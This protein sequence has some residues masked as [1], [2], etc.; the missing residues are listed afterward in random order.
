MLRTRH[1]RQAHDLARWLARAH[2]TDRIVI[3]SA[4]AAGLIEVRLPRHLEWPDPRTH[5][6]SIAALPA[7]A[8]DAHLSHMDHLSSPGGI[9]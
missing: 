6:E 4:T 7:V 8:S 2:G 5:E 9:R 3:A 1:P